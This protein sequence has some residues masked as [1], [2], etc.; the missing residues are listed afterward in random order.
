[1]KKFSKIIYLLVPL[2]GALSYSVPAQAAGKRVAIVNAGGAAS[3]GLTEFSVLTEGTEFKLGA[4]ETISIGYLT[5]C[6]SETITG[7]AVLIGTKESEVTGGKVARESDGQCGEP[8]L[9]LSAAESQ[10]GATIAFRPAGARRH[11]FT[12][13]PVLLGKGTQ[14]LFVKVISVEDGKVVGKFQSDTG[15]VDLAAEKLELKPGKTYH[16]E[17]GSNTVELEIDAAAKSGG[18]PH[19]RA[20]FVD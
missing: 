19:E 10:Q 15:R 13:T 16:V 5:S 12:S 6:V 3:A 14:T 18:L 1:M 8:R 9:S 17:S 20:V 7:G 11:I 2:I 4:G